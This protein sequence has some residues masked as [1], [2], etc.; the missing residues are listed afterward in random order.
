VHA[1]K[2]VECEGRLCLAE[3]TASGGRIM[4][5]SEV[6]KRWPGR[7]VVYR[8]TGMRFDPKTAAREI[9][10][11]TGKPY[12]WTACILMALM[13]SLLLGRLAKHVASILGP[14]LLPDCSMEVALADTAAGSNPRPDLRPWEV[15]PHDL[16]ESTVYEFVCILGSTNPTEDIAYMDGFIVG[17][18][19]GYL[20]GIKQK[21]T[22]VQKA[23]SKAKPTRKAVRRVNKSSRTSKSGGKHRC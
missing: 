16:A 2:I 1:A 13:H 9:V 4:R 14:H 7:M 5:L 17:A 8:N 10:D 20:Q 18:D 23:P 6:V 22:P 15:E 11:A 19:A 21:Q 12:G 3:V